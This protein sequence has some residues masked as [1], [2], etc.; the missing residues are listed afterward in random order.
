MR[1]SAART[2]LGITIWYLGEILTFSMALLRS[3]DNTSYGTMIDRVGDVKQMLGKACR[4][5]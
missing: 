2:D 5:T 4:A 1:S 3:I